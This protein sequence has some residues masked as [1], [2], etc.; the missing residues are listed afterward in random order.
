EVKPP[1]RLM[2][3]FT[4]TW[5]PAPPSADSSGRVLSVDPLLLTLFFNGRE[6]DPMVPAEATSEYLTEPALLAHAI[7]L[8]RR[9]LA[10]W[11]SGGSPV[12]TRQLYD[13]ALQIVPHSGTALLLCH[14]VTKAFARG[15]EAIPWRVINRTTGEYSDGASSYR[16][17]A[18]PAALA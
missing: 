13:L 6:A 12:F 18:A 3:D 4:T 11:A 14:N 8:E 17:P 7:D 15:G 1:P 2:D 9:L 16:A 10:H 5:T